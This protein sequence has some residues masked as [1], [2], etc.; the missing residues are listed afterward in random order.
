MPI[1]VEN[2]AL[3]EMRC[4]SAGAAAPGNL[5][6]D[7]EIYLPSPGMDAVIGAYYNASSTANG[8]VGLGRT[9]SP[10]MTAQASGLPVLVTLTRGDGAQV[11][12]AYNGTSYVPQ[13]PGCLNSL[14]EDSD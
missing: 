14:V 12:Y 13:T 7:P 5:Q 3:R 8:T 9:V 2:T 6:V 1:T 10:N 11:S 4:V